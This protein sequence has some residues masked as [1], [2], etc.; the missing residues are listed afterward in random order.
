MNAKRN[1]RNNRGSSIIEMVVGAIFFIPIAL[2]AVDLGSL[3]MAEQ[4][5]DHIAR[6]AARAASNQQKKVDAQA[7]AN[8]AISLF[9]TNPL[10]ADV[11]VV[12]LDY[13][14]DSVQVQTSIEARVPAPIC[15]FSGK[16]LMAQ[17]FQPVVG[18][19]AAL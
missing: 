7:A 4:I 8:K 12:K 1:R 18:I 9:K 5:N 17:S 15:G 11:K 6:D 19:P 10:I 13:D 3:A 16:K 14:G 2:F